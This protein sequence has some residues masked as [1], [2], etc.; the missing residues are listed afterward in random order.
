[1]Y[2]PSREH[3][4]RIPVNERTHGK[5]VLLPVFPQLLRPKEHNERSTLTGNDCRF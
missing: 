3:G 5:P 1:M 2:S 4:K